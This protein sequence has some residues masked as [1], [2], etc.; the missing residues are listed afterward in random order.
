MT[1]RAAKAYQVRTFL[2]MPKLVAWSSGMVL[3][4]YRVTRQADGWRVMIK[5][6]RGV[7]K[8]VAYVYVPHWEDALDFVTWLAD[9]G[10]LSWKVDKYPIVVD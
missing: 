9:N 2:D 8:L 6:E 7:H 4:E 10:E 1:L 3:T 5:A